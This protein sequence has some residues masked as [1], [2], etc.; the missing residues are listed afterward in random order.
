MAL[1]RT[2]ESTLHYWEYSYNQGQQFPT[3]PKQDVVVKVSRKAGVYYW[4]HH[5]CS[6]VKSLVC[7]D[8]RNVN[9]CAK[10]SI[11]RVFGNARRVTLGERFLCDD[12][13][14]IVKRRG[15]Y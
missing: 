13:L 14:F 3:D 12:G 10:I 8:K 6:G 4:G 9:G 2:I 11:L 7:N 5:K 1:P 15:T